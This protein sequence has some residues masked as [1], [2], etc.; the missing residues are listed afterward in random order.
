MC[1][2]ESFRLSPEALHSVLQCF[3]K[4]EA[5]LLKRITCT[6]PDWNHR[7]SLQPPSS[8]RILHTCKFETNVNSTVAATSVWTLMCLPMV[9]GA[10][11]NSDHLWRAR[12]ALSQSVPKLCVEL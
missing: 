11:A 12:I 6:S 5:C 10:S 2:F 8:L 1:L 4:R 3:E 7:F 9:L